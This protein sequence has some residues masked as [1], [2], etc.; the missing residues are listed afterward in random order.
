MIGSVGPKLWI[1]NNNII[2]EIDWLVDVGLTETG[3]NDVCACM[4]DERLASCH[5]GM[6][7]STNTIVMVVLSVCVVSEFSTK[8]NLRGQR[9]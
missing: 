3:Q 8:H 2:Q 1:G 4:Y 9:S 5:G 6:A 7:F